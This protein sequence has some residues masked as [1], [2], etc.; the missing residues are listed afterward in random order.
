MHVRGISDMI[1]M[2]LVCF[3]LLDD[4]AYGRFFFALVIL[5]KCMTIHLSLCL[6]KKFWFITNTHSTNLFRKKKPFATHQGMVSKDR[7]EEQWHDQNVSSD[8]KFIEC[9]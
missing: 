1:I 3:Y 6:T 9:P 5:A 2:Q 7:V 4:T 8:R